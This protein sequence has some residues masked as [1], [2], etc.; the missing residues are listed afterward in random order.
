[1]CQSRG[2]RQGGEGNSVATNRESSTEIKAVGTGLPSRPQDDGPQAGQTQ[3]ATREGGGGQVT[4]AHT[5][6]GDEGRD[7]LQTAPWRP[8]KREA[9]KSAQ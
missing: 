8:H 1:M 5:G 2:F 6:G 4:R 7:P 3:P 9:P